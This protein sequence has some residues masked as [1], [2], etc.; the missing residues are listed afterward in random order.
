MKRKV[1]Q[2]SPELMMVDP[3]AAA[4]ARLRLAPPGDCLVRRSGVS[5]APGLLRPKL[6]P[7]L[8]LASIGLLVVALVGVPKFGSAPSR[9]VVPATTLTPKH[10]NGRD[11]P[12]SRGVKLPRTISPQATSQAAAGN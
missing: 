6:R 4:V 1:E 2:I 3:E 9:P 8:V 10:F 12:R 11:D 7:S 5:V